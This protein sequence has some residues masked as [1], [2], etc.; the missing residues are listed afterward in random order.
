MR[1]NPG[2]LLGAIVVFLFFNIYSFND[3]TSFII[4]TVTLSEGLS[5]DDN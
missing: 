2:A 3:N 1:V 5:C 4:G